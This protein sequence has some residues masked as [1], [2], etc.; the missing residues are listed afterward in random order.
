MLEQLETQEEYKNGVTC[1]C[2]NCKDEFQMDYPALAGVCSVLIDTAGMH[3]DTQINSP[4]VSFKQS[5][6][7][8]SST[9]PS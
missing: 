9:S 2:R 7:F 4:Y 3:D 8:W 5:E 1:I 6:S